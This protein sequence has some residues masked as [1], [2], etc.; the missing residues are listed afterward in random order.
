MADTA[1]KAGV[2]AKLKSG[3][4]NKFT[5]W[6]LFPNSHSHRVTGR[7]PSDTSY[8]ADC[9]T[10]EDPEF[11]DPGYYITDITYAYSCGR[12]QNADEK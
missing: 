12:E 4:I 2:N 3:K 7:E 5:I 10:A 9:I 1:L 11:R 8:T 6:G